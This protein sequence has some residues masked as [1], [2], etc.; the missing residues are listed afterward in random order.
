VEKE[1]PKTQADSKDAKESIALAERQD[2]IGAKLRGDAPNKTEVDLDREFQ[3]NWRKQQE[4]AYPEI[5]RKA[6]ALRDQ[7]P[8]AQPGAPVALGG[9]VSLEPG[10]D[11]N[12]FEEYRKLVE[13]G[14]AGEETAGSDNVPPHETTGGGTTI[15]TAV[16]KDSSLDPR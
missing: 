5:Y 9:A 14:R 8:S 13:K 11:P 10:H 12:K 6:A 7:T 16:V 1:A 4:K 2:E 3:A 15:E